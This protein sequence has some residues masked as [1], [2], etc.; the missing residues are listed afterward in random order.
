MDGEEGTDETVSCH[1][2][3]AAVR[4][5]RS[6]DCTRGGDQTATWIDG[7]LTY[8]SRFSEELVH[9]P[10]DHLPLP[11]PLMVSSETFRLVL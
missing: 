7:G 10:R 5:T 9:S 4:I 8:L 2:R 6:R 1:R 11:C 3:A